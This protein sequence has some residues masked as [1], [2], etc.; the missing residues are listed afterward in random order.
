MSITCCGI[1]PDRETGADC[2]TFD[3]N[4][5]CIYAV[6]KEYTIRL[7]P[8]PPLISPPPPPLLISHM[9]QHNQ[10]DD[11]CARGKYCPKSTIKPG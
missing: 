1:G 8:P 9:K 3:I 6:E 4:A 10:M 11:G 5:P 7:F 2:V